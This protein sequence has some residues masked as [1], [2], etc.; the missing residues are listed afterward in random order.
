MEDRS[1]S[2]GTSRRAIFK[3]MESGYKSPGLPSPWG[4]ASEQICRAVTLQGSIL[5][6]CIL[7]RTELAFPCSHFLLLSLKLLGLTSQINY[8]RLNLSHGACFG[9][10]ELELSLKKKDNVT[11]YKYM[12]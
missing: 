4:E 7:A 12:H 5:V 10:N 6:V 8:L 9:E 11:N 3:G 1:G 2:G